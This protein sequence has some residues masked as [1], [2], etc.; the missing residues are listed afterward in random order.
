MGGWGA[1]NWPPGRHMLADSVIQ[2]PVL[3]SSSCMRPALLLTAAV[4][5]S[6]AMALSPASAW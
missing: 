2:A 3:L 4:W 6:G 1:G 5:A